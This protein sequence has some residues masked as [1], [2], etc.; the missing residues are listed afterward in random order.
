[1]LK[2]CTL[3]RVDLH[4][5]YTDDHPATIAAALVVTVHCGSAGTRLCHT[6]CAPAQQQQ[7][8]Q[9]QQQQWAVRAW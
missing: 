6:W 9:Q 2:G 7:R 3:G 8:Q 5:E 4:T 1:M